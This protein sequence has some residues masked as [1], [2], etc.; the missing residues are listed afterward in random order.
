MKQQVT[1]IVK[2]TNMVCSECGDTIVKSLSAIEGVVLVKASWVKNR[3]VVTYNL[4]QIRFLEIEKLLTDMGY[5]SD[6]NFLSRLKR[7]WTLF[8]EKNQIDNLKHV[9]A[10]CSKPPKTK[11]L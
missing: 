6:K 2:V 5:P 1:T 10:C 9:G 3:V 4:K 11:K 7:G 8:K